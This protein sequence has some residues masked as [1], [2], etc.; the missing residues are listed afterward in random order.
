MNEIS[1][2][3]DME[4]LPKKITEKRHTNNSNLPYASQRTKTE[5]EK[6]PLSTY[7][8]GTGH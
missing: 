2:K 7:T 8:T 6:E 4:R 5:I 3:F 1:E